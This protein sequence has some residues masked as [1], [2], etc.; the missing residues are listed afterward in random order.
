MNFDEA[1]EQFR[2]PGYVLQP[3]EGIPFETDKPGVR[4]L[5]KLAPG[6]HPHFKYSVVRYDLEPGTQL[7][8]YATTL[9][10]RVIYCLEGDGEILL[11]GD[12][13]PFGEEVF[14]HLGEGFHAVIENTGKTLQQVFVF[15]FGAS[16]DARPDLM[17]SDV[18]GRLR[19]VIDPMLRQ[20]FGL[21]DLSQALALSKD[22]KGTLIHQ[23]PDSGMSWWQARP[24]AG[25]VE[26]KMS[27]FACDVHHYAVLM[28]TIFPGSHVRK[29][30]HNQLNETLLITKGL[31]N[32]S[33]DGGD[34]VI[35]PKGSLIIA[36][37]NVFHW[38]GNAGATDVQNFAIIDPPGVEGALAFT[39]RKREKGTEW[40]TDI[41]RDASTGK[42]LHDR[43]GFVIHGNA[44]DAS[45][46]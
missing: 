18:E 6:S 40:P 39:G 42:M 28:Q 24:T 31:A 30:A 29:H 34:E 43:F 38:W 46:A 41:V 26:V 11:N 23:M 12:R 16:P 13:K 2:G 21:L 7:D 32:A 27:P 19:L 35:C 25:W 3:D 17:K 9:A 1:M 45:R 4:G 14:V 22:R 37:R 44:A 33:L 20:V 36:G 10:G 8:L 15:T 5:L